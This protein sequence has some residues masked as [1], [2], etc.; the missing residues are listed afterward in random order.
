MTMRQAALLTICCTGIVL[1]VSGQSPP[2]YELYSW[3]ESNGRWSFCVWSS[4]SGVNIT[5]EQVFDRRCLL[6]GVTEVKRRLSRISAGTTIFWLD[7]IAG[8]D[9]KTKK[10]ARL[11]LPP[12]EM[13]H[14]IRR[15][16]ESHKIIV[17]M[18]THESTQR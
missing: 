2:A 14:D 4:P 17:D 5:E 11:R 7:G 9:H 12:Q 13:I 16:A 10:S 18:P 3:Q 1:C 6:R 8:E 15:Y